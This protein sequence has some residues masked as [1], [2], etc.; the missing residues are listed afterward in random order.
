[1]F[2]PRGNSQT[3]AYTT[4][5][6]INVPLQFESDQPLQYHDVVNL[7]GSFSMF[8]VHHKFILHRK[9]F[10]KTRNTYETKHASNTTLKNQ[11]SQADNKASARKTYG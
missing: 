8:R 4:P 9:Q 7:G 1:M 11:S 10:V 5:E 3:A 6:I 2:V